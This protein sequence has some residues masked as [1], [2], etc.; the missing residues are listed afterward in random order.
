[1]GWQIVYFSVFTVVLGVLA[2]NNA[3]QATSGALN[4]MLDAQPRSRCA[5]S[6]IEA[7]LGRSFGVVE[8][9]G[10]ALVSAR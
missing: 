7:A 5:C 6:R 3:A 9:A 1:M 4:T 2:F 8:L 10:A